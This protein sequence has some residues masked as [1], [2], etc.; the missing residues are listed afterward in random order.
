[1]LG[2]QKRGEAEARFVEHQ[3]LGLR[4]Q[5]AADRKHLLLAAGEI[6]GGDG[7][8]FMQPRKIAVNPVPVA[9]HVVAAAHGRGRDQVFVRGQMFEH[10]PTLEYM[11]DP[12]LDPVLRHQ[13]TDASAKELHLA[14]ADLTALRRK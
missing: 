1:M 4:H 9:R 12:Q 14:S 10:P 3:Q 7:A 2:D 13:A 8:A 11:G 6:A 5:G